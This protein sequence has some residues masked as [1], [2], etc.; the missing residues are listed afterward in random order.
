MTTA[1]RDCVYHYGG[2]NLFHGA[3]NKQPMTMAVIEKGPHGDLLAINAVERSY[4]SPAME[5]NRLYMRGYQGIFCA[6]YTGAEGRAYE[7]RHVAQTLLDQI[8]ANR[9]T[10]AKSKETHPLGPGDVKYRTQ[11]DSGFGPALWYFAGPHAAASKPPLP[12]E[13]LRPESWSGAKGAKAAGTG[14]RLVPFNKRSL[15]GNKAHKWLVCNENFTLIDRQ[16]RRVIDFTRA[17]APKPD[18][19]Y[20]LHAE[21]SNQRDRV[22]QFEQKTPGIKAWING[23]E[24][25]DRE[26]CALK[27]GPVSLTL[28]ITFGGEPPAKSFLISPRFWDCDDPKAEEKKW[29]AFVDKHRSRLQRAIELAPKSIEAACAAAVLKMTK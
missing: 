8:P 28:E 1:S 21:L 19:V 18:S 16:R 17:V 27:A 29:L 26:R 9:P 2:D 12:T 14:W 6:E 5:G 20:Y 25:S 7:A 15:P 3:G 10:D 23:V 22:A 24:V 4:S 11:L 13:V